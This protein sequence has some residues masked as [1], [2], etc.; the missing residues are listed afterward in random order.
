MCDRS[1]EGGAFSAKQLQVSLAF[2]VYRTG[3]FGRVSY[4]LPPKTAIPDKCMC[5]RGQHQHFF[6]LS[7]TGSYITANYFPYQHSAEVNLLFGEWLEIE[8]DILSQ[9]LVQQRPR[10]AFKNQVLSYFFY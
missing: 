9:V 4:D 3:Y 8:T 7:S 10:L 5:V 6:K 2:R 1:D